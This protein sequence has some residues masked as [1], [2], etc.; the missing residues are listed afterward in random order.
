MAKLS[1]TEIKTYRE[2]LLEL[3]AYPLHLSKAMI[4][5]INTV[6]DANQ[7]AEV[8]LAKLKAINEIV[9]WTVINHMITAVVEE[10]GDLSGVLNLPV[11]E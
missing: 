5:S 1:T 7:S 4:D 11:M 10:G 3:K 9:E 2:V 6:M 8:R